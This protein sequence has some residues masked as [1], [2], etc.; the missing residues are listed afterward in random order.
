MRR[1]KRV[2]PRQ[3]G[4]NCK[5]H[6]ARSMHHQP[7]KRGDAVFVIACEYGQQRDRARQKRAQY[8]QQRGYPEKYFSG[9]I[10]SLSSL[11][12]MELIHGAGNPVLHQIKK[13]EYSAPSEIFPRAA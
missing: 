6:E 8:R 7:E 1:D 10:N 13:W 11:I 12:F 5:R 3:Y 9:H 2:M 4:I